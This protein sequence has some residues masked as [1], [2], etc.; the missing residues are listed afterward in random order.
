M[1]AR[2]SWFTKWLAK[3]EDSMG[4][5]DRFRRRK[6]DQRQPAYQLAARTLEVLERGPFPKCGGCGKE[7]PTDLEVTVDK[8]GN[9]GYLCAD[10]SRRYAELLQPD[11]IRN[12]WM[13]CAC[14]Y[15]VLAGTEIDASVDE[16]DNACPCCTSDVSVTLTNLQGDAPIFR[17]IT[18]EPVDSFE[19]E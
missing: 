15:R 6:R 3:L 10:C 11:S 4:I 8:K 12:F 14:G 1:D 2:T 7:P 19:E 16:Q 13:C 5:L 18:G 9:H 17:G